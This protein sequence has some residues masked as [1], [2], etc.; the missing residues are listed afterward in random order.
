MI[1]QGTEVGS[2]TSISNS[3]IGRNC[4]IGTYRST[5]DCGVCVLCKAEIIAH[6]LPSLIDVV[7]NI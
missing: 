5:S 6:W 2:N 1:G 3:V 7:Y 4:K